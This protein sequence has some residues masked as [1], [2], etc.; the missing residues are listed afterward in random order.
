MAKAIFAGS[1]DP[2]TRG[3]LEVLVQATNLFDEVC[4][5][6][7][8]NPAKQRTFDASRMMVALSLMVN[9]YPWLTNCC[10]IALLPEDMALV[11][12]A[13]EIG[14]TYFVRGVRSSEDFAYEE[15]MRGINKRLDFTIHT[16]Y[17]PTDNDTSSTMVRTC[18][19]FGH[20]WSSLVPS[21]VYEV[22]C[23]D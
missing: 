1:F 14:A 21:E 13:R 5:V 20:R 6:L 9:K 17:I 11:D 15:K 16:V 23:D 18:K 4:I 10:T 12:F 2:F 19:Q 3:H 22:F 8:R 7:A